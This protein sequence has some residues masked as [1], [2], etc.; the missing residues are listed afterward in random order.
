MN[1]KQIMG[2]KRR[3]KDDFSF[4]PYS[5]ANKI[6]QL[7]EYGQTDDDESPVEEITWSDFSQ[8][9][10]VP[11]SVRDAYLYDKN[12]KCVGSLNDLHFY[13]NKQNLNFNGIVGKWNWSFEK[14][15]DSRRVKDSVEYNYVY[16]LDDMINEKPIDEV[17][18][19][20]GD[21]WTMTRDFTDD[22]SIGKPWQTW[23][24]KFVSG[25]TKQDGDE[26][27]L[28]LG[29]M[30]K[31]GEVFYVS[32]NCNQPRFVRPHQL[33]ISDSARRVKDSRGMDDFDYLI[34]AYGFVVPLG[35]KVSG[36]EFAD[37]IKRVYSLENERNAY[38]YELAKDLA[39]V[40][41]NTRGFDWSF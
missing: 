17:I 7:L 10:G 28:I 4:N 23:Y 9:Y 11:Y 21:D 12:D 2:Y 29:T 30:N 35:M 41:H 16:E 14:L 31:G 39:W 37:R 33:Y 34:D 40:E 26:E 13:F 18:E 27:Y 3:V 6:E 19:M 8:Y 25:D 36:K 15:K 22:S 1:L 20:L 5:R 24:Y 32:T 38:F